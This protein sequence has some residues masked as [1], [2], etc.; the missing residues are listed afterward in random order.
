MEP[1]PVAENAIDLTMVRKMAESR[2]P[3]AF[4]S[5]QLHLY[6]DG[7]GNDHVAF[8]FG[9]VAGR[10]NVLTRVHSECFTAEV[11][12]SLRCDCAGQ[13]RMALAQIAQVGSGILIYLR[14]EGRGIGLLDKLRAYNLQDLGHDTVDANLMLGRDSDERTYHSAA[15]ILEDLGVCS[16]RLLTNN[17]AKVDG[18]QK[19]GV[20]VTSRTSLIATVHS[21]NLRYLT[22]K[23]LRMG[24]QIEL[25]TQPT[26]NGSGHDA[27]FPPDPVQEIAQRASNFLEVHNR[28]FVTLSYAQS[29][30]GCLSFVCGKP[31]ALSGPET[32]SLT[33]RLRSVHDAIIVGVGTV[34]SDNPQ[35]TVRRVPGRNPQ[36]VVLDTHLRIPMDC[37]L[38]ADGALKPWIATL[39][40]AD[41]SRKQALETAG[42]AVLCAPPSSDGRVDLPRLL[43]QLAQLGIRSVMVEG[44]V[45]VIRSV[46]DARLV[47][48]LVTT[49]A[50]RFVGGELGARLQSKLLTG[51]HMKHF[52]HCKLG[53]D[54]V[55]WGEPAWD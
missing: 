27:Y 52:G 31:L 47:D 6:R 17:P 8:V 30:D 24:H 50:P 15:R 44:G 36:P 20:S 39:D 32:L 23:V 18:L 48:Y 40:N 4:G 53:R 42:A 43:Q 38:L 25:E 11:L 29:L 49:V 1:V 2:I 33:H 55:L 35:L 46:I 7:A 51:P 9:S 28:P 54:L 22:T 19:L 37:R 34:I 12:G 13:L 45:E 16:V 41:P 5:F 14:Q 3:T 10:D 26:T 21:E